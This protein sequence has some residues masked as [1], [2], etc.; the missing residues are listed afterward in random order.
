M[1]PF[2]KLLSLMTKPL[3]IVLYLSAVAF[4]FVYTDK[5]VA[6]YFLKILPTT[7]TRW[8]V[9]L[10][11]LGLG[12]LY[13]VGFLGAALFFRYIYKIRISEMRAWFL[14][15]CVVLCSSICLVLK[16]ILGRARPDLWFGW[17]IYGFHGFHTDSTYWSFPSGH[18]AAIMS[19]VFGIAAI[20]PRSSLYVVLFGLMVA[21]S[22][23]VLI[24]HYPSDILMA[25][26]IALMSVGLMRWVFQHKLSIDIFSQDKRTIT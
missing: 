12:I 1:S 23:I 8:L 19:V 10:T 14:W 26:W 11:H 5:P 17:H 16:I 21:C 25:T 6:E 9:S 7:N 3:A 20:F 18:T 2:D 4:S 15:S 24:Q 22:R 13:L